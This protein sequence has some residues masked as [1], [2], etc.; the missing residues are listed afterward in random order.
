MITKPRLIK[1]LIAG[2]CAVFFPVIQ[3]PVAVANTCTTY[4]VGYQGPLTGPE[5]GLGTSQLNAVKFAKPGTYVFTLSTG[6]TKKLVT[7]KVS[8]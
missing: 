4:S 1:V 5:A 7:V 6:S 2:L 3:A 8:K